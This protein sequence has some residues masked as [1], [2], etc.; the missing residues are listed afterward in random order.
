[1]A[2]GNGT[3]PDIMNGLPWWVKAIVIVGVPSAISLGL[4]W[5]DRAQLTASVEA[6][7]GMLTEMR[8]TDAA[9]DVSMLRHFE[10]LSQQA[11]E[12]NRILTA[13]CVNSA[14]T[15]YERNRCLGR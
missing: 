1:M 8:V 5:S 6:N 7:Q 13:S 2:N 14:K 10:V 15:E 12:T 4:V 9:H 11:V 3:T